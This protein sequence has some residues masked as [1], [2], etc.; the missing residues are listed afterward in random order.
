METGEWKLKDLIE[1]GN[2]IIN[3][4]K[5]REM[6]NKWSSTVNTFIYIYIYITQTADILRLLLQDV[7]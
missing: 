2:W 1:V 4:K 6:N 3:E 5:K 7:K